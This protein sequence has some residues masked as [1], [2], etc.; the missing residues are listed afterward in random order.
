ML[1]KL[2]KYE[3]KQTSLYSIAIMAVTIFAALASRILGEF[4]NRFSPTSNLNFLGTIAQVIQ[5]MLIPVIF[6]TSAVLFL[7]MVTRF[8]Q[9]LL[10]DQGYLTNTLPVHSWQHILVKSTTATAWTIA[11]LLVSG[12]ATLIVLP[13]FGDVSYMYRSVKE[14]LA[15]FPIIVN[16]PTSVI[17]IQ[18][19]IMAVL[20]IISSFLT[21]YLAIM[22]GHQ[23]GEHPIIGTMLALMGIRV[24]TS[25][26]TNIMSF[27]AFRMPIIDQSILNLTNNNGTAF[28]Y[29]LMIFQLIII[30]ISGIISFIGSDYLLKNRLNLQ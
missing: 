13:A 15:N 4:H 30:V 10:T 7:L 2:Y 8:Y 5:I 24:A 25:I 20:S 11:S 21:F 22:L 6:F 28:Y 26:I 3:F 23:W 14:A 1:A 27:A 29:F 17:L 19:F 16:T 12:V 9:N 18:I